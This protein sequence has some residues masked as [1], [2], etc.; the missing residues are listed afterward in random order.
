MHEQ[1]Y[2]FHQNKH[3]EFSQSHT[4]WYKRGMI[5]DKS[6]LQGK[7]QGTR[8]QLSMHQNNVEDNI[9]VDA[10]EINYHMVEIRAT[11]NDVDNI[12]TDLGKELHALKFDVTTITTI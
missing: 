3:G 7:N 11:N 1:V 12:A 5:N 4:G 6:L 2:T 10:G 8:Q 9:Q